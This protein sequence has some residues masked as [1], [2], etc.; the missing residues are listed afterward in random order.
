MGHYQDNNLKCHEE[1]RKTVVDR[2]NMIVPKKKKTKTPYRCGNPQRRGEGF[3]TQCSD[4][5]PRAKW[6]R[7]N[8]KMQPDIYLTFKM[9]QYF[10]LTQKCSVLQQTVLLPQFFRASGCRYQELKAD[11]LSSVS[12][13]SFDLKPN[14]LQWVLAFLLQCFW[15]NLYVHIYSNNLIDSSTFFMV[16]RIPQISSCMCS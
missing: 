11:I 2:K 7:T 13:S 8:P 9:F 6:E 5:R 3:T 1:E 14:C 12:S 16:N 15:R 4:E 10:L